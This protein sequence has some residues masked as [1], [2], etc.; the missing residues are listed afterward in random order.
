[1]V[2]R[3][4]GR[5]KDLVAIFRSHS[6]PQVPP[7]TSTELENIEFKAQTNWPKYYQRKSKYYKM[8]DNHRLQVVCC[9][10]GFSAV[11]D[12]S[13]NKNHFLF[14]LWKADQLEDRGY[15]EISE[16]FYHSMYTLVADVNN[17]LH[18]QNTVKPIHH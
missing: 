18:R 14:I 11:A 3:F 5:L 10:P 8:V 4:A 16:K 9:E 17:L 1:M 12:R 15:R 7:M 13:R 6:T 2:I